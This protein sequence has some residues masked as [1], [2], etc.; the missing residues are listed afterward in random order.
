MQTFGGGSK[1]CQLRTSGSDEGE[2]K[3]GDPSGRK[4]GE[5]AGERVRR[6]SLFPDFINK[7]RERFGSGKD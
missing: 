1:N 7:I 4:S 2:S 6:A 3:E 5:T